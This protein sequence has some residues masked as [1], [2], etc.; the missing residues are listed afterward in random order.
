M[1]SLSCRLITPGNQQPGPAVY[2]LSDCYYATVCIDQPI[3]AQQLDIKPLPQA[4]MPNGTV[5][6][7][8]PNA[9]TPTPAAFSPTPASEPALAPGPSPDATLATPAS[10]DA[11][12]GRVGAADTTASEAVAAE[13]VKAAKTGERAGGIGTFCHRMS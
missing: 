8:S 5:P 11:P 9:S 7:P 1:I 10:A 12:A 2:G 6:S 3:S 13:P 4:R